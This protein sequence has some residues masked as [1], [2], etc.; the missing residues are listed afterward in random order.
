MSRESLHV[1]LDLTAR[2]LDE[3]ELRRVLE[4]LRASSDSDEHD[5]QAVDIAVSADQAARVRDDFSDPSWAV[6]ENGGRSRRQT[7]LYLGHRVRGRRCSFSSAFRA[8]VGSRCASWSDASSGMRSSVSLRHGDRFWAESWWRSSMIVSA[9]LHSLRFQRRSSMGSPSSISSLI[10]FPGRSSS[11]PMWLRISRAWIRASKR[12][13]ARC[14]IWWP[15]RGGRVSGRSFRIGPS[16]NTRS[17]VGA[18]ASSADLRR[19]IEGYPEVETI[20]EEWRDDPI[21]EH[22]S[23][24]RARAATEIRYASDRADRSRRAYNG[25]SDPDVFLGLKSFGRTEGPTL[26]RAGSRRVSRA[27]R[28]FPEFDACGRSRLGARRLCFVRFSPG[29]CLIERLHQFAYHVYV[30]MHDT[31]LS[32]RE[33]GHCRRSRR[34]SSCLRRRR[35]GLHNSRFT[36]DRCMRFP[37]DPSVDEC[38]IRWSMH[39]GSIATPLR[40]RR[41]TISFW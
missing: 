1:L 38:V 21:H 29:P 22:E 4:S 12:S 11:T 34:L 20:E 23:L 35:M 8:R 40:W 31:I 27:E 37:V 10:T 9:I 14:A 41:A 6:I 13:R 26:G 28:Y 24:G 17:S 39:P 19:L 33:S 5:Y 25:T 2:D 36:R 18:F 30:V 32:D 3:I 7:T 15:A 16:S